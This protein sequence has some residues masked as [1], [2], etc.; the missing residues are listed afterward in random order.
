MA[1]K[2]DMHLN[3]VWN[4]L[5]FFAHPDSYTTGER[6]GGVLQGCPRKPPPTPEVMA[7]YARR[8]LAAV[9]EHMG[10]PVE[11]WMLDGEPLPPNVAPTGQDFYLGGPYH[12]G[13]Y[14]ICEVDT[15]R[16]R[17]SFNP[18]TD[19]HHVEG[20]KYNSR[21]VNTRNGTAGVRVT[22]P[23]AISLPEGWRKCDFCGCT[24]NAKAR[25]CCDQGRAADRATSTPVG[26]V[27]LPPGGQR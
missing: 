7:G 5:M 22:V 15:G 12:D 20:D 14:S 8:A 9:R 25:A 16:V 13:T 1:E 2:T 17:H 10:A 23:A 11:E 19:D 24:T 18:A 27:A 26:G 3:L 21:G 4:T 6:T